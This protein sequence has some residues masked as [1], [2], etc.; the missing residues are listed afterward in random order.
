MVRAIGAILE[1]NGYSYHLN[2][3]LKRWTIRNL[4]TETTV[5]PV[6]LHPPFLRLSHSGYRSHNLLDWPR[7]P[8]LR[9]V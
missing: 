5:D 4:N 8:L 7:V 6:G 1:M 9:G 2:Q 3:N